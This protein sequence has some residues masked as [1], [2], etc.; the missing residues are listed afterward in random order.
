MQSSL[1]NKIECKFRWEKSKGNNSNS[2]IHAI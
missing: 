2:G 1:Q